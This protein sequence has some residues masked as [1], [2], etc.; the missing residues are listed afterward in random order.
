MASSRF[1]CQ[2]SSKGLAVEGT[3]GQH[4]DLDG[5][6]TE[7][8]LDE[9]ARKLERL[10]DLAKLVLDVDLCRSA[11]GSVPVSRDGAVHRAK[12][13]LGG[14]NA[15]ASMMSISG[16]PRPTRTLGPGWSW[17]GHVHALSL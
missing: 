11:C 6:V 3:E 16:A 9:N 8:A 12:S 7:G 10:R 2:P 4:P 15:R 1:E 13:G 5:T 17:P 14:S